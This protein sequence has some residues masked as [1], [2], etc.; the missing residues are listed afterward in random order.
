MGLLGGVSAEQVVEG[1]T[2]WQVFG[3]QAD[4]GELGFDQRYN[5]T[6]RSR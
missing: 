2:A 3:E 1:V 4:T 6:I 5:S